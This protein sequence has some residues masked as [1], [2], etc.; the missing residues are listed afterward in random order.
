MKNRYL[1]ILAFM[2]ALVLSLPEPIS[3]QKEK[4]V[5][6]SSAV[7]DGQGNP[8]A[9]AS[10]FSDGFI[11]IT[12][13]DGRFKINVHKG[14]RIILEAKGF[15]Q[16][17]LSIDDAKNMAKISLKKIN[18]KYGEDEKVDVAF[19]KVYEGDVVGFVSKVDANG[20][21]AVNNTI[22]AADALSGRTLGLLGGN[23][24][25]GIGI[26]VS[27]ADL[28]GSGLN[29]GNALFVV[30][31]LPRDIN[32]LRL[33]EVEDIT[34]LKDVNAAV[35]YGSAA[36]NGVVLITTKRGQAFKKTADFRVN[37]GL[38]TPRELPVYLNSA[39]YMTYFNKARVNDG[40]TPL[41]SDAT[42]ENYRSGNKYHYPSIDFYS[43]EY[44]KSTKE[45]F[46]LTSEF[47]G[48]NDLAVYYA[49]IGWYSAGGLL[50]FGEGKNAR[51]NIFNV[52]A[53]VDLK[54]NNWI[55]TSV[56]GS[57]L[58]GNNKT[59]RGSFWSS[60]GTVRPYEF[61]PLL[62]FDLIKPDNSLFKGHKTDVD[63]KY[64]LGGNTNF[65]TNA[66][67]DC[68][69]GGVV[70]NIYRK[71]SFNNRVDFDLNKF[72][73]GLTFHT[74]ISFDYYTAYT[75]TIANQYSVYEGI[76]NATGD[77][78][79]DL[80]QSGTDARPG[81]QVV[82]GTTFQRRNGFYGLFSY[83]R[84]FSDVHQ[85]TG[86][87][88]AY[89]SSYKEQGDFQIVKQAHIG[90][91]AG[92]SFRKKYMV[93]FSS[94]VVNS[95]RLP[96][97]N[98]VGFSPTLGLSWVASSE[99]F[100]KSAKNVDYLKLRLSG[101]ILNSDLLIGG[102]FYYDNRY[103][104]SGSYAW[105]EGGRSRSGVVSS[106][107]DNPDLTFGKRNELNFGIEGLFFNKFLGVEANL[108]YDVY[109]DQV[110]QP[111]ASYPNFYTSFTPFKNY[112][113]D[114]YQG[115]E[116]GINL[117]K[118]AGNWKFQLGIN[119]LYVTSKRTKVDE[120]Y[121]NTYQYRKGH[122]VDATFGL[123][124]LGF[125]QDQTDIDNS[126]KQ[127]FGTVKPG[128]IKYKDQ[129]GDGYVDA[130]DEVYLRR[131]QAPFSGG[132]TFLVSYKDLTLFIL[133]EG[134]SGSENFK[135]SNYYWVDGNDKYSETVLGAWTP[136]TKATATAPRLSSLTNSNNFRRSSYWLYNNDYFSVN[137]VQ[138]TW[139]VP[140]KWSRSLLMKNM[141]LY[142]QGQDLYQFAKNRKIRDLRTEAEPY[143]RTFTVGIKANF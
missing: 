133:G 38:S 141:N 123:Q 124:A 94:A 52:R 21:N 85:V 96:K 48:G 2:A 142:V 64:L 59:Q 134:R 108:F 125:F 46:D 118:T 71:F 126:P 40:L 9:G 50:N 35:L 29:S 32:S 95:I 65:I 97:G 92:Y 107:R 45:Y 11:A 72:I 19:R 54:I 33:S 80:V 74:N 114:R 81:T 60:A 58:F 86:S 5:T 16:V 121:N 83:D 53:N 31:G 17:I 10:V 143:Y 67:A 62:P 113:S 84:T 129:N 12:D 140:V 130:N 14:S 18:F 128:D 99:D 101:G 89:G 82:G 25:R 106:W 87:L 34:I 139:N 136:E 36:L 88:F 24:I 103:S 3:A 51:N 6:V 138:L 122:P 119:T 116:V 61:V 27:V 20:V 90:L 30:D 127:L 73:K 79:V 68:Y 135:E 44:L 63:G 22:G 37:Y 42:I 7:V 41:Y 13:A 4:P 131:Y 56:D 26:G 57:S 43:D 23:T 100:M 28:T 115:A 91:Q 117:N 111:T 47:S 55:K 15:E 132:L 98:K 69:A 70:E 76:W 75:Q 8:L 120:I 104:T 1:I 93:D 109:S 110:I 66:I 102:Y 112:N 105:Y 137:E 77:T 39:D 78:I 49:N